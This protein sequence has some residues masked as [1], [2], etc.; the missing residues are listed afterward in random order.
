[1]RIQHMLR[2]SLAFTLASLLLLADG[3]SARLHGA[4]KTVNPNHQDVTLAMAIH[5]DA[6]SDKLS[7]EAQGLYVSAAK[8][9]KVAL[10][11]EGTRQG[12]RLDPKA[13]GDGYVAVL[14]LRR[15]A[16]QLQYLGEPAGV[17]Q[18]APGDGL[19]ER[20]GGRVGRSR[21]GGHRRRP[22]SRGGAGFMLLRPPAG[23]Q[24]GVSDPRRVR[25]FRRSEKRES[26]LKL[27][28]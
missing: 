2:K 14:Q 7:D 1:M 10:E 27:L 26:A 8:V 18:P 15:L 22:G 5:G 23:V 21:G 13:L 6:L 19:D 3:S 4:S 24:A 17:D 28:S 16:Q 25:G 12:N 11:R 20:Q 9:L